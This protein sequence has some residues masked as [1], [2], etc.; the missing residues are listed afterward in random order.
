MAFGVIGA[1]VEAM[2]NGPEGMD[3]AAMS[4]AGVNPT[5]QSIMLPER[6]FQYWPESI[7]DTIDVGWN[8]KDIPGMSSA[9]AQW[10]SNGGRTITFEAHFHRFMKPVESRSTFENVFDPVKL[11]SPESEYPKDNR[12]YNV[13]V[14]AEIRYLRAFCYPSYKELEGYRTSYPPPIAL[15]AVPGLRL[16]DSPYENGASG[17]VYAVMTGCDVTYMLAFPD[18]TPRRASVSLTFRL[19]I[20]DP[21]NKVIVSPGFDQDSPFKYDGSVWDSIE[22]SPPARGGNRTPN[23]LDGW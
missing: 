9:L 16:S 23:R 3:Y 8:F 18:G 14:A 4:I 5:D 12:P 11:N 19:V 20:Q 22:E 2:M 17:V 7:S 21:I 10:A 1:V 15:L 13:D 6:T